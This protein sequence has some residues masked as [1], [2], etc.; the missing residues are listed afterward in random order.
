MRRSSWPAADEQLGTTPVAHR[1]RHNEFR[2]RRSSS[3]SRILDDPPHR[4]VGIRGHRQAGAPPSGRVGEDAAV[5]RFC[6]TVDHPAPQRAVHQ[7]PVREHDR[8]SAAAVSSYSIIPPRELQLGHRETSGLSFMI[9]RSSVEKPIIATAT[10]AGTWRRR[11]TNRE[12]KDRI[13]GL[14]CRR[15]VSPPGL[16]RHG[17]QA[18]RGRRERPVRLPLSLLPGRKGAARGGGDP[19]LRRP[20]TS[21]CSRASPCRADDVPGAIGGFFSRRRRTRCSRPTTRTPVR[22]PPSRSR[23]PAP[24]SHCDQASAEVF[25]SWI[26]GCHRLPSRAPA[27]SPRQ[28]EGARPLGASLSRAPSCSPGDARRRA[29]PGHRGRA[30]SLPFGRLASATLT[31]LSAR[32][33]SP[34]VFERWASHPTPSRHRPIPVG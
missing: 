5:S 16:Q 12:R 4:Q 34:A 24:T 29:A 33:G 2:S 21:S 3:S 6:R 15:A 27:S 10:K 30:R 31:P 13:I 20:S 8:R 18:D 32:G 14:E 17:R 7:Q 23:S 1:E 9:D 11:M 25:E 19:H 22:S 26:D 28:G